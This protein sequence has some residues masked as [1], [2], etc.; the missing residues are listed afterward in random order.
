[1]TDTDNETMNIAYLALGRLIAGQCPAG[2]ETASLGMEMS[3]D[4]TLLRIVT[5]QADGTQVQLQPSE[6]GARDILE[7][8]RGIR[9]AM[10][11]ED[12]GL[13]R[14]CTVTL[15]AGGRFALDVEY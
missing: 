6:D 12:G 2:F 7:S 9:Q 1:M 8:L 5:V 4:H 10:A 11:G 15:G 14:K 13:W 3:G